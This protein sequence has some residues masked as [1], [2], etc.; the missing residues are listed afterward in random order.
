ME[1]QILKLGKIHHVRITCDTLSMDKT[2][3]AFKHC[4]G[5][6]VSQEGGQDKRLHQHLLILNEMTR[7][8][9]KDILK[10]VYPELKGNKSYS[11]TEARDKKQLLKYV[12]KDGN[13][14]HKGF[15]TEFIERMKKLSHN[16]E[17]TKKKFQ[18]YLDQV[19]TGQIDLSEYSEN[20]IRTKAEMLQPFYVNHHI[21]HV[22]SVGMHIGEIK[23]S[24]CNSR[25]M[26]KV[27]QE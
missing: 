15:T 26:E 25:I 17:S 10:E 21:A 11:I 3:A 24:D 13:Y 6:I 7:Q 27:Y 14:M 16:N 1:E 2:F 4:N 12:L 23:I 18:V 8:H 9:I 19:L 20:I 22:K 5:V